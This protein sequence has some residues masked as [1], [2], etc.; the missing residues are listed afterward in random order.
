PPVQAPTPNSYRPSQTRKR[1][2][3]RR[4][5]KTDSWAWV[6][7]AGALLGMTLITTMLLVFVLRADKKD[8]VSVDSANLIEPTSIFGD[9]TAS[10]MQGNSMLIQPWNGSQ[11]FTVLLMGLDKRPDEPNSICRTDTMM[12]VSI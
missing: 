4:S 1:V 8:G 7:I 6:V 12:V 10:E 2:E 11:R 9:D 5:G 3:R